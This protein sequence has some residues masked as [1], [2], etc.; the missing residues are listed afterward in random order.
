V[1]KVG[2]GSEVEVGEIKDRVTDALC[3]TKAAISEG[4]VPGGGTA[5]LYAS[6][7]LNKLLK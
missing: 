7:E 2:G 4:I 5:L 3:A 1:I 6:L